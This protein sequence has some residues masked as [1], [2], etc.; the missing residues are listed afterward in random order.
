MSQTISIERQWFSRVIWWF[1][2]EFQ[3]WLVVMSSYV[4]SPM[5]V[6]KWFMYVRDG[7]MIQAI[8][9]KTIDRT[10][11]SEWFWKSTSIQL[12]CLLLL[13][14]HPSRH[15]Y[16]LRHLHLPNGALCFY[17]IYADCVSLDLNNQ[18][19]LI[20]NV[21]SFTTVHSTVDGIIVRFCSLS[22]A[23]SFS[24]R[25]FLSFFWYSSFSPVQVLHIFVFS[26]SFARNNLE[27]WCE[28]YMWRECM[29]H[30]SKSSRY[31]FL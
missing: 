27:N 13:T 23:R 22:F 25:F 3:F 15:L 21:V 11:H 20:E 7:C 17:N 29:W 16:T 8:C 18:C 1:Y 4:V 28:W 6:F 14:P 12:F 30:T 2:D 5:P 31:I 26:I 9:D 19:G 24:L 10:F